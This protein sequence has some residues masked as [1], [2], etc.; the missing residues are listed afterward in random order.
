VI[1]ESKKL[2]SVRQTLLTQ[3][4]CYIIGIRSPSQNS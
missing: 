1:G 3:R 4:S 2:D